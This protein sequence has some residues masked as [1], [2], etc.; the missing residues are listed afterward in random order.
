MLDSGPAHEDA[1]SHDILVVPRLAP[2]PDDWGP[3]IDRAGY[4]FL[5]LAKSYKPPQDLVKFLERSEKNARPIIYIG[6]GSIFGIK[7]PEPSDG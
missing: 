5:D 3:E 6:F 7:D 1:C 4:V 2:K